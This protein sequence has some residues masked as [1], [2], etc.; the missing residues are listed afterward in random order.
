[1]PNP[2]TPDSSSGKT[3]LPFNKR[4]ILSLT[5]LMQWYLDQ[6]LRTKLRLLFAVT[7]GSALLIVSLAFV[8][9]HVYWTYR[10]ETEQLRTIA[11]VIAANAAGAIEFNDQETARELLLS[12]FRKPDTVFAALYD[13]HQQLFASVTTEN[14]AATG[15]GCRLPSALQKIVTVKQIDYICVT[16]P[17]NQREKTVGYVCLKAM[18]REARS[19]ITV[20]ILIAG[21]VLIV[22]GAFSAWI[23]EIFQRG[24]I[25]S[26]NSLHVTM[27]KITRTGDYSMRVETSSRDEIGQLGHQFNT[28][29]Q[30][31]Q[32]AQTALQIANETLE[33]RVRERT[34]ELERACE[35]AEAANRAKSLFLANMSHEIR[36]PMTAIL[37]YL[38]FLAEPDTTPEQ[39]AEYV[40]IIRRNGEHL[41]ALINDIL[42]LSRIEAGRMSLQLGTCRPLQIVHDVVSL[43]R[44]R[45]E[46]KGLELSV[47]IA[48]PVPE[49]ITSDA[50]RLHQIL[51]NLVGNA[52]KFTDRGRLMLSVCMRDD[53]GT[54]KLCFAVRDTGPGIP[55]SEHERIFEAFVQ[56]ENSYSRR[57]GGTGL[58]LTI[59]RKL[60]RLLGGDIIVESTPGEGSTFTLWIDPGPLEGVRMVKEFCPV[61]NAELSAESKP[62]TKLQGRVLLAEDGFDNQ[63]L[64]SFVLRRAGFDVAVATNGEEAIQSYE[65]AHRIGEPF[66]C[67]LMDMQMPVMD[68]Y[69]AVRKL[70]TQGCTTPIIALT[71]HAMVGDREACLQAGCDDYLS[72]PIDRKVLVETVARYLRY[73]ATNSPPVQVAPVSQGVAENP[74]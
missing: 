28:M 45:A 20:H 23:T 56:A 53:S 58:G 4:N 43:M 55:E 13:R 15:E 51:V 48:T 36:T 3:E 14:N 44:V 57:Y 33:A 27:D 72:K 60:A 52:I 62:E 70:R 10:N 21:F 32:E 34:K 59:S 49:T 50:I 47:S 12:A 63:R 25:K 61:A 7:L 46:E 17:V 66:G 68:G 18:M 40:G 39:R 64:I 65:E 54:P 26:L 11:E 1:V 38:D 42:D 30:C 9:S 67:I 37:G 74:L 35:A 19:Q 71:A 31:I 73:P 22:A 69:T 8:G 41:L 6:P 16:V 29:L 2:T 5:G 24:L